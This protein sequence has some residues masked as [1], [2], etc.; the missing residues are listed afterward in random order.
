MAPRTALLLLACVASVAGF[1]VSATN[2]KPSTLRT[3]AP[4]LSFAPPPLVSASVLL[5]TDAPQ[6]AEGTGAALVVGGLLTILLAG[7]P[8]LFLGG[9][10]KKD[11]D[12]EKMAN[13]E[14][15][16]SSFEEEVVDEEEFPPPAASDENKPRGTI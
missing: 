15:G 11:T 10:Q 5:A 13:L 16:L 7:L 8:I 3:S 14:R 2:A 1:H 9:D 6:M 12:S 4:Q